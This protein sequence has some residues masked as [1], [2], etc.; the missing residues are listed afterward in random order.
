M[1]HAMYRVPMYYGEVFIG[2][3]PQKFLVIF[4]TGSGQLLVPSA[5]CDSAATPSDDR[6]HRH[7][8]ACRPSDGDLRAKN[9]GI[10]S[11]KPLPPPG[12]ARPSGHIDA[13]ADGMRI[14]SINIQCH[15]LLPKSSGYQPSQAYI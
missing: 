4:D 5:K 13:P 2:T 14:I 11:E 1:R 10:V 9:E 12:L 15:I 3:P 8:I 7:A 6:L